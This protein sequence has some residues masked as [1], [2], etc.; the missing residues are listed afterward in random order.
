MKTIAIWRAKEKAEHWVTVKARMGHLLKHFQRIYM[1]GELLDADGKGSGVYVYY[2]L[3]GDK[4]AI[5]H[6]TGRRSFAHKYPGTNCKCHEADLFNF[7]FDKMQ[8][9]NERGF[10]ECCALAL[11]PLHEALG[12]PEPADWTITRHDGVCYTN[13][14][15]LQPTP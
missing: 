13:D 8:H 6:V 9:Y 7:T 11:V 15:H 1:N 4:P 2:M 14:A 12:L 3:V 5:C 10:E